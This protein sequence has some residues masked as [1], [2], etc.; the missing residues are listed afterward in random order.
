[1]TER[2]AGNV[3]EEFRYRPFQFQAQIEQ[4][5]NRLI[6]VPAIA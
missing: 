3:V 5:G 1:M 4:M 2:P 6:L